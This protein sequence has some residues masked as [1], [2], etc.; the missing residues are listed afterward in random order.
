MVAFF[1]PYHLSMRRLRL[2]LPK[3]LL[4]PMFLLTPLAQKKK[5]KR[6]RCS[7]LSARHLLDLLMADA[8]RKAMPLV[9]LGVPVMRHHE[10][11]LVVAVCLLLAMAKAE[12]VPHS[13][14]TLAKSQERN[15]VVGEIILQVCRFVP[16]LSTAHK[17]TMP[18]Q[19]TTPSCFSTATPHNSS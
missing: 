8:I 3:A 17:L 9:A 11:L 12:E 5:K 4:S 18:Q 16:L 7:T 13:Q 19:C 6:R 15:H 1:S 2:I 10:Q 14:R